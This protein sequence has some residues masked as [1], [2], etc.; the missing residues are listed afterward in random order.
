MIFGGCHTG[1]ATI[2][3][4]SWLD[5]LVDHYHQGKNVT[6]I[7]LY[8]SPLANLCCMLACEC[9]QYGVLIIIINSVFKTLN[10]ERCGCFRLLITLETH[11]KVIAFIWSGINIINL[12]NSSVSVLSQYLL[13]LLS[14]II[15]SWVII[16]LY[17]LYQWRCFKQCSNNCHK[18]EWYSCQM[19]FRK[20]SHLNIYMKEHYIYSKD[21]ND[22]S[23][24]ILTTISNIF[25]FLF[26]RNR[27]GCVVNLL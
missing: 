5:S 7:Q 2:C 8:F 10:N 14:E 4:D 11:F 13:V 15:W 24:V 22:C 1:G 21:T 6:F 17:K 25:G 9:V 19:C 20:I 3:D 18:N 12:Y 16:R 26:T 23:Y 27:N